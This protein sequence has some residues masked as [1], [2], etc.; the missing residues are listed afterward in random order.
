MKKE[1]FK[2]DLSKKDHFELVM[3]D[4]LCSYST[5]WVHETMS[6]RIEIK[7]PSFNKN[8][9]ALRRLKEWIDRRI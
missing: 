4:L 1:L 9:K 6:K 2:L 5:T 8:R 3:L 7:L